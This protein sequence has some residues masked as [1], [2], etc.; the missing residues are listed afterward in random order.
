MIY[1]TNGIFFDKYQKEIVLYTY[2]Y[3]YRYRLQQYMV[4]GTVFLC[5]SS[6]IE[7]NRIEKRETTYCKA[8]EGS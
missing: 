4:Y 3:T 6:K 5:V 2:T 7:I 8:K 1:Y